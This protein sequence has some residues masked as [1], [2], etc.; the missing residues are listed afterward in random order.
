MAEIVLCAGLAMAFTYSAV[1]TLFWAR[2]RFR[3]PLELRPLLTDQLAG[4]APVLVTDTL[5]LEAWYYTPPDHRGQLRYV[6]D[7]AT[8]LRLGGS[9]TADLNYLA[10]RNWS[11]MDVED[12]DTFVAAHRTFRAYTSGPRHW[13]LANLR[14]RGATLREIGHE[15]GYWLYDVELP[16]RAAN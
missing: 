10:L 15:A 13:Q 6:A 16:A 12:W 4:G 3:N 5:F 9:D 14:E 11:P 1:D 8:A 2:P 7:P